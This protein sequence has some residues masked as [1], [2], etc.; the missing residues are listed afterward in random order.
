MKSRRIDN[1]LTGVVLL[2]VSAL[3]LF[4]IVEE[5]IHY[6]VHPKPTACEFYHDE[7]GSITDCS[8]E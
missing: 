7:T 2:L 5:A 6:D 3:A 8:G 4:W 1:V